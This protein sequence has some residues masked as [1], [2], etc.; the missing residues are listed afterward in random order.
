MRPLLLLLL[1]CF[2]IRASA[3]GF[4]GRDQLLQV[5]ITAEAPALRWHA[6][7]PGYA[8]QITATAVDA[9]ENTPDLVLWL[10]LDGRVVAYNDN[11]GE[12][13]NPSIILSSPEDAV[14]S[15]YIDSFNGVSTGTAEVLVTLLDPFNLQTL[16]ESDD[17]TQLS[18]HLPE[19]QI[20]RHVFLA[21]GDVSISAKDLSG[22]LDLYIR[23]YVEEQVIAVNDDHHSE[24]STLGQFDSWLSLSLETEFYMLEVR[25]FLGNAGQIE[26]MIRS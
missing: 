10:V 14:Y 18:L 6:A 16:E 5:P 21:S 7:I 23:L 25:D 8:I 3:Q 20:F 12:S 17:L 2:T 22:N 19:S 13:K 9:G 24:D 15:I 26:I 11:Q 4:I 1:L